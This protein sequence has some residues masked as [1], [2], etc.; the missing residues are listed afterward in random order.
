[1][2]PSHRGRPSLFARPLT[3]LL[4]TVLAV[5]IALGAL[6]VGITVLTGQEVRSWIPVLTR[7]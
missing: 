1:M 5:L 6:A 7:A 4:L 2:S 3:W